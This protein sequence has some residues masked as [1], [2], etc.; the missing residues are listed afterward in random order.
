MQTIVDLDKV[1][2]QANINSRMQ[3]TSDRLRNVEEMGQDVLNTGAGVLT[4]LN[5]QKEQIQNSRLQV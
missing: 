5:T 4:T 3:R 1:E 2:A